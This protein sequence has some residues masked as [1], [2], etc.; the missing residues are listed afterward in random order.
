MERTRRSSVD[1]GCLVT[2]GKTSEARRTDSVGY[3]YGKMNKEEEQS[4]GFQ[5]KRGGQETND[6]SGESMSCYVRDDKQLEDE[7][8]RRLSCGWPYRSCRPTRRRAS[9]EQHLQE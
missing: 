2:F 6:L 7:G 3:V 4:K 9:S 5:G 1:D 8:R